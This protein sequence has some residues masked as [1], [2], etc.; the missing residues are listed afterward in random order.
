MNNLTRVYVKTTTPFYVGL[1]DSEFHM[2]L[3]S[4][5][6][7]KALS[8]KQVTHS[9]ANTFV[10]HH[11]YL[12]RKI[13]IA[14]NVSYGLFM[15]DWCVGVCMFGFPVWTTFPGLVPP[16]DP[17]E[18]P[19][20]IRLCTVGNLPRNSESYFVGKCL[21]LLHQAWKI[22][23]D[24]APKCVVSLCDESMGFNGSIYK[25]TNFALFTKT[26]GRAANPGGSH[27]RWGKNSDIQ[28]S[29]KAVYLYWYKR[30][31][32]SVIKQNRG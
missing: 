11:H 8:V 21:K 6:S 32:H 20:L 26:K 9:F 28:D 17:A 12:K 27:G 4:I 24:V 16:L 14:R 10:L 23:T 2:I 19:E 18:C 30:G 31:K 15:Q 13:Y 7:P 5:T 1:F 25:A 3:D 22:E 29:V